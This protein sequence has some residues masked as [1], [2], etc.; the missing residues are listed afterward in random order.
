MVDVNIFEKIVSDYFE[1]KGYFLKENVTYGNRRNEA[2]LLGVNLSDNTFIH[3]EVTEENIPPKNLKDKIKTKFCNEFIEKLYHDN[4]NSKNV[5]RIYVIWG[6]KKT[7]KWIKQREIGEQ[8]KV[9]IIS[10]GEIFEFLEEQAEEIPWSICK[11]KLYSIL[12]MFQNYE[13]NEKCHS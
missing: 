10:Y 9:E 13:K 12:K 8:H 4:F 11:N 6:Y 5:K 1:L 7:S 2:D 3:V